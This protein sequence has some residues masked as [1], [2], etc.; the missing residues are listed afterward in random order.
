MIG[1]IT[2]QITEIRHDIAYVSTVSGVTYLVS[3]SPEVAF[4][5]GKEVTLYTH[6]AVREDAL[7]LYGFL[8]WD[9]YWLFLKLLGVDGVGPKMAFTIVSSKGYD[10]VVD[11]IGKGDVSFFTQIKGVGKKTAQRMVLDLTGSLEKA[12]ATTYTPDEQLTLDALL[13]LG[14]DKA[15]IIEVMGSLPMGSVEERIT[16]A[17]QKLSSGS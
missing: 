14:F 15:K 3:A 12:V 17:L 11:A 9:Q 8:T 13:S 5:N 7:T 10:Q 6:L 1:K 2:G 16:A 4:H